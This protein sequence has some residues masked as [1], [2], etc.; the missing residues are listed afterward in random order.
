M[1]QG[2]GGGVVTGTLQPERV[3]R[4]SEMAFSPPTPENFALGGTRKQYNVFYGIFVITNPFKTQPTVT[5][6]LLQNGACVHVSKFCF[7]NA[8]PLSFLPGSCGWGSGTLN[9]HENGISSLKTGS[10]RLGRDALLDVR[11]HV[12]FG[13]SL[14]FFNPGHILH[15]TFI[16]FK[17]FLAAR[18]K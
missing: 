17:V 6:F 18:N 2:W 3:S 15:L 14:Y 8:T 4:R 16:T 12:L 1:L 5:L 9:V 13:N 10:H 7:S 11:A